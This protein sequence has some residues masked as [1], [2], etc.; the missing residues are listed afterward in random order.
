MSN[1][2]VRFLD[3]HQVKIRMA[4]QVVSTI[5]SDPALPE[6][7]RE[8]GRKALTAIYEGASQVKELVDVTPDAIPSS[9]E[10][11]TI[12]KK[13]AAKGAISLLSRLIK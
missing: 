3:D 12:A 9:G 2:V 4:A 8:A 6:E 11:K 13:L 1:A 5:L 10:F 7:K